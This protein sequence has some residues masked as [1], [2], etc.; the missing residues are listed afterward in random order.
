MGNPRGKKNYFR[1]SYVEE[2]FGNTALEIQ[3]AFSE[4]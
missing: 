2:M 4:L 1:G 3:V